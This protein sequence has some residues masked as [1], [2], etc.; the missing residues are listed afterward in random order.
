MPCSEP[1]LRFVGELVEPELVDEPEAER[2]ASLDWAPDGERLRVSLGSCQSDRR[3]V[4]KSRS[5]EEEGE[6]LPIFLA[7]VGVFA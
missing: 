6:D 7:R 5:Y 2:P 1:F 4:T 3:I